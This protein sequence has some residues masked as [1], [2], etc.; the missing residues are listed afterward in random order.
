M[1]FIF[2]IYLRVV[3]YSELRCR[4]IC[5]RGGSDFMVIGL[6]EKSRIF[7]IMFIYFLRIIE[8]YFIL[9]FYVRI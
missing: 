4:L 5:E 2:L 7:K 8:D 3:I 6:I 9:D 1:F